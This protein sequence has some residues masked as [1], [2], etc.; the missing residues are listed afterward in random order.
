MPVDTSLFVKLQN[1]PEFQTALNKASEG[2]NKI[3][4][5]INDLDFEE[6]IN[7]GVMGLRYISQLLKV[8]H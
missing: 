3:P 2:I 8:L 7:L 1:D 6:N 4:A 5:E